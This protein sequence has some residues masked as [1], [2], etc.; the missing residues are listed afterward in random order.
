MLLAWRSVDLVGTDS[1]HL[2][3]RRVL[4]LNASQNVT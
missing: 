1:I 3:V 4:I 2:A